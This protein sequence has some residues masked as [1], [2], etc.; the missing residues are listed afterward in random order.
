MILY[1]SFKWSGAG[2]SN[3]LDNS[4]TALHRSG[5]YAWSD[6]AAFQQ[7]FCILH[8]LCFKLILTFC[9]SHHYKS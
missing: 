8:A 4:L 3:V 1:I 9:D 5:S 2:L 6:K 7:L